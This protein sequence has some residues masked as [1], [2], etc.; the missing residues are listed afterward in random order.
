MTT[1]RITC[2]RKHA[3]YERV[4]SIGCIDTTTG[5]EV[6]FTEDEAIRQIEAGTARFVVRDDKGNEAAVE[7][8]QREGRKFLITVRDGIKSDNLLAMPECP[9]KVAVAPVPPVTYRP[10]RP[11]GSHAVFGK[12]EKP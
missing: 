6:R 10:V 4:E 8:E 9:A 5:A 11:A 3:Q 1:Y 7:V 2:K 12:W